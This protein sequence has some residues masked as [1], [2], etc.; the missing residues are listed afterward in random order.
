VLE[1]AAYVDPG[2]FYETVAPLMIVGT[3]TLIGISTLTSEINFYTRLIR[4]KDK[5]TGLPLFTVMQVELACAKC[6]EEGKAVDCVHL[7]HLVPRWQ[8]SERHKRL[9]IVMQDRPDLIESELSGLA[10]DSLQQCFRPADIDAL[11]EIEALNP[12]LNDDIYICID[13]AGMFLFNLNIQFLFISAENQLIY[14]PTAGGPQSDYAFVSFQR[15][16]GNVTIVGIDVL[17]HCK[18]PSK[19]FALVEEHIAA[20]RRNLYRTNSKVIIFTERNLGFEVC[21]YTNLSLFEC[22]H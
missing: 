1:E 20:L 8:S 19:Q 11:F 6:K 4:L 9:K 7:L 3:T 10:F 13:P 18:E 14:Q 12:P 21:C 16:R 2:F 5:A 22:L 15:H 17:S